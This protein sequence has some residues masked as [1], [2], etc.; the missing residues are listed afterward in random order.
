MTAADPELGQ[1]RW[2]EGGGG[3]FVRPTSFSSSVI[4]S[5]FNPK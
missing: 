1:K 3:R 4:S 2:G 5:F